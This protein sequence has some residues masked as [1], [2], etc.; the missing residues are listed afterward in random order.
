M[1]S[2]LKN[3]F[4]FFG[5]FIFFS[6]LKLAHTVGHVLCANT[7]TDIGL[8]N[9]SKTES[10]YLRNLLLCV[11]MCPG[12]QGAVGSGGEETDGQH[13]RKQVRELQK[14]R[15][16]MTVVKISEWG[17]LDCCRRRSPVWGTQVWVE[18]WAMRGLRLLVRFT[19]WRPREWSRWKTDSWTSSLGCDTESPVSHS[20]DIE[21]GESWKQMSVSSDFGKSWCCGEVRRKSL[22]NSGERLGGKDMEALRI[23][24][25][26]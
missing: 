22:M 5:R 4:F 9:T 3:F 16:T 1:F 15:S 2:E 13:I 19:V 14:Q 12:G 26:R 10:L 11:S 18:A 24:A 7:L 21:E 8:T 25:S 6:T 17:C 20:W 23:C